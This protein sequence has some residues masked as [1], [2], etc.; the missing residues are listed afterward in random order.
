MAIALPEGEARGRSLQR[1][2]IDQYATDLDPRVLT[3]RRH[4]QFAAMLSLGQI[5]E[6]LDSGG[7]ADT[8]AL[9][10]YRYARFAT[11]VMN[12]L[13]I[14]LTLPCF[15]LREPANLLRQSLLCA[16]LAIPAVLGSAIGMMADLPGIPPAGGVFLPIVI[17]LFVALV[18]WTYFR[19]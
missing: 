6:I 4:N 12:L 16:A 17:L 14:G 3:V 15:L 2:P 13:V 5:S 8:D 19:T 9:L 11:V 18:P 10:R 1:D 7:V